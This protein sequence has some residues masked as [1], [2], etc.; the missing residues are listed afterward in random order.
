MIEPHLAFYD[1]SK[2]N[3]TLQ[4]QEDY[5]LWIWVNTGPPVKGEIEVMVRPSNMT[6]EFIGKLPFSVGETKQ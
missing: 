5:Y 4:T 6:K 3:T 2:T 1:P